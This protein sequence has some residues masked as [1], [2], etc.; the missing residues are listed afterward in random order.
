M[1]ILYIM[2]PV[3]FECKIGLIHELEE[4][5]IH[6]GDDR[7]SE[8]DLCLSSLSGDSNTNFG[9]FISELF[10]SLKRSPTPKE[11]FFWNLITC[12]FN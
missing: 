6:D 10:V 2:E 3:H 1:Y 9:L 7:V 12:Y 4:L 8:Y 11:E 5:P